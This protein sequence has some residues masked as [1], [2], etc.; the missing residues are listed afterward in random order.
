MSIERYFKEDDYSNATAYTEAELVSKIRTAKD[1]LLVVTPENDSARIWYDEANARKCSR[2]KPYH[3][4]CWSK[5]DHKKT[6]FAIREN[7]LAE[8]KRIYANIPVWQEE[9]DGLIE[10]RAEAKLQVDEARAEANVPN[11]NV[12]EADVPRPPESRKDCMLIHPFNRNRRDA[13]FKMVDEKKRQSTTA[14][15]LPISNQIP[16]PIP[17]PYT[18]PYT[19]PNIIIQ[20]KPIPNN[21]SKP[22]VIGGSDLDREIVARNPTAMQNPNSIEEPKKGLSKNVMVIGGVLV[23][24]L[25]AFGIFRNRKNG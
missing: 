14:V 19:K 1:R 21:S 5:E 20:P 17:I 9:L 16:R 22:V 6:S 11:T 13:C 15:N 2:K 3:S 12:A 25:V 8:M 4:E 18:R 10:A 24:G 7:T 23:L